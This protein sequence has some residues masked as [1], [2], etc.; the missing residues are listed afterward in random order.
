VLH[1]KHVQTNQSADLD[2][3]V[4]NIRQRLPGL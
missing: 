1:S 2:S 4:E 3:L